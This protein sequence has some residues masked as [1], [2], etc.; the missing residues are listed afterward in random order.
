MTHLTFRRACTW[1]P[2]ILA[3]AGGT[4]QASNNLASIQRE[5]EQLQRDIQRQGE[6]IERVG[7]DIDR[8]MGGHI[9]RIDQIIETS[10]SRTGLS[11]DQV[12][13]NMLAEIPMRRF[14]TPQETAAAIAFL[15]SPAASYITGVN[16]PVDGGRTRSL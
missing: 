14:A 8:R 3:T 5:A 12:R 2:M 16:L 4:A 1:L 13:E 6:R 9:A 10:C 15:C 11:R 7:A